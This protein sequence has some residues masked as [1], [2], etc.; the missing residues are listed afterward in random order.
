MAAGR[1]LNP[2][3][4]QD[5][6]RTFAPLTKVEGKAFSPAEECKRILELDGGTTGAKGVVKHEKRESNRTVRNYHYWV[7]GADE[8]LSSLKYESPD[9]LAKEN[10]GVMSMYYHI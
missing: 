1:K 9:K 10:D 4:D 5:L 7:R 3:L 2:S 8:I 6:S